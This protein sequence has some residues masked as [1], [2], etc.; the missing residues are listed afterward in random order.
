MDGWVRCG[1]VVKAGGGEGGALDMRV[2]VYIF[3]AHQPSHQPNQPHFPR[4]V[5]L[6]F[7]AAA[8]RFRCCCL[9]CCACVCVVAVLCSICGK[10]CTLLLCLNA[11]MNSSAFLSHSH[12]YSITFQL[13]SLRPPPPLTGILSH[14][15]GRTHICWPHRPRH[16]QPKNNPRS[17]APAHGHHVPRST[18]TVRRVSSPRPLLFVLDDLI[19]VLSASEAR[20]GVALRADAGGSGSAH[21]ILAPH[22]FARKRLPASVHVTNR[23]NPSI[24]IR[25]SPAL[26]LYLPALPFARS[27]CSRART[28]TPSCV[29][30]H[31]LAGRGTGLFSGPD[32][33]RTGPR[34]G[35]CNSIA[36]TSTAQV[37]GRT[38]VP[39][40][41]ASTPHG[42]T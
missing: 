16:E 35:S 28:L 25:P 10:P 39:V 15:I 12:A 23:M 7:S 14:S 6:P 18:L 11:M 33:L 21:I 42:R 19:V 36:L 1:A 38:H 17:P 22:S 9:V 26:S 3:Q 5:E 30:V 13:N 37:A 2:D 31:L 20:T 29:A 24:Q 4:E 34:I 27:G 32:L 41:G 40:F 8:F